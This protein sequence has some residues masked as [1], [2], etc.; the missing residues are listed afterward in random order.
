MPDYAKK[1]VCLICGKY[2]DVE[3]EA[4]ECSI[5]HEEWSTELHFSLGEE[6]PTAILLSKVRGKKVV[7][8]RTYYPS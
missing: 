1:W 6:F 7:K 4:K 8:S 3:K 5:S 2:F